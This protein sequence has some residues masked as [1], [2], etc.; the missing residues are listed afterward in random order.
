VSLRLCAFR[1]CEEKAKVKCSY[2]NAQKKQRECGFE[3]EDIFPPSHPKKQS[4]FEFECEDIFPPSHLK[5]QRECGFECEDI[6]L[7]HTQKNSVSL[8]V[9]IFSSFTPKKTA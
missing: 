5:K 3:C 7:L 4:E 2:S 1:A 6:F 8:S 9:R